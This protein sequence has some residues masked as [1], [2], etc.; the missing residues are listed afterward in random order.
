MRVT[1]AL[2]V[3]VAALL[4]PHFAWADPPQPTPPL[5]AV[6]PGTDVITAVRKGDVATSDGQLFD[7]MTA[8]RWGNYLQQCN[9]RLHSD[10]FYQYKLDQVD[11]LTL[12]KTIEL[13]RA[14]YA[15][16]TKDLNDKLVA[17]EKERADPPFYK[18][19]WFGA[20]AGILGSV[21]V[22]VGSVALFNAVK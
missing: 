20:S 22:L 15:Q 14:Q 18:T 7:Q 12:Q 2:R 3:L 10:P 8:L 13:E 4:I 9:I 11:L 1:K 16:V 19:A 17:S 6:P 21:L 5:T